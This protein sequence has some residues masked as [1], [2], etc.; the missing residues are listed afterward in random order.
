MVDGV[1]SAPR[2]RQAG[3]GVSKPPVPARRRLPAGAGGSAP[4]PRGLGSGGVPAP[5]GAL[6]Q[7]PP[8]TGGGV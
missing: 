5:A 2:P 1:A 6:P 4:G 8:G 7:G 3:A